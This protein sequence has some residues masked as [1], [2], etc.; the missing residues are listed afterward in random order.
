M[1]RDSSS[2][3]IPSSSDQISIAFPFCFSLF[4]LALFTSP[5]EVDWRRRNV[6]EAEVFFLSSLVLSP[7]SA[8]AAAKDLWSVGLSPQAETEV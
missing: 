6:R 2:L 3:L 1:W 4:L 5:S 7:S 8:Q